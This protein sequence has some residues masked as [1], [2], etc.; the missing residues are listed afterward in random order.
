MFPV[1]GRP[2]HQPPD[3]PHLGTR[4]PWNGR[5]TN[6]AGP[7]TPLARRRKDKTQNDVTVKY[8][9]TDLPAAPPVV[10]GGTA[11]IPGAG[12]RSGSKV[13]PL[14]GAAYDEPLKP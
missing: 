5:S 7:G 12:C 3:R 4:R 11:V 1:P 9:P 6:R 10:V 2:N 13:R 14:R 8:D